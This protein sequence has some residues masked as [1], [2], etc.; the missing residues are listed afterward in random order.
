M[1]PKWVRA[2]RDGCADLSIAFF[3]KQ[4]GSNHDRWRANIR[5]KG[6]DMSEWPEDLRIR[7]FPVQENMV[8]QSPIRSFWVL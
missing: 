8:G 2:L 7:N 6:D 3:M 5:G 4:I 1:K